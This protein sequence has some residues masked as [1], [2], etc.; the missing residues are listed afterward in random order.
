MHTLLLLFMLSITIGLKAQ[1]AQEWFDSGKELMAKKKYAEAVTAFQKAT[2]Q[3]PSMGEAWYEMGWSYNELEQY[4]LAIEALGKAQTNLGQQSRIF[5]ERGYAYRKLSDAGKAQD[6]FEKAI[7][8]KPDY[9]AAYRELAQLHY[10]M[11]QQYLEALPYF[12]SFLQLSSAQQQTAQHWFRK[13]YCEVEA[14][15]LDS[16]L[17]SLRKSLAIDSQFVESWNEIA[18]IHY[19]RRQATEAIAAYRKAQSIDS[20]NPTAAKGLGDT[21]RVLLLQPAEAY[22]Q[23]QRAIRLNPNN[24]AT[25]F[26]LAWCNNEMREYDQAIQHLQKA[27][28][29]HS[30]EPIFHAE[31]GYTYYAQQKWDQALAAIDQSIQMGQPPLAFY[32]QGLVYVGMKDKKKAEAAY[33]KLL[34]LQSADAPALKKKIDEM[35]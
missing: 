11:E 1:T 25:Y 7:E 33:L 35:K 4:Q 23:Y 29:L 2:A 27:I 26:G 21:Y 13:A 28:Q 31:I 8:Q 32:Y 24:A 9:V 12:R 17:F 15:L 22:A 19:A 5:F 10:E 30:R 14:N 3:N 34:S 20:S 6:N 18:Y 16:A